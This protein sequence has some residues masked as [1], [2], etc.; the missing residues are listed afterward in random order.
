MQPCP[1]PP[2][3]TNPDT[4][5]QHH[6]T[7]Q[8]IDNARIDAFK[9]WLALY[10]LDQ[11]YGNLLA[12]VDSISQ[13]FPVVFSGLAAGLHILIG[14]TEFLEDLIYQQE[15]WDD[16]QWTSDNVAQF[17]KAVLGLET[18]MLAIATAFTIVSVAADAANPVLAL[19]LSF[20]FNTWGATIMAVT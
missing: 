14:W 6:P 16:S 17:T 8:Q 1:S 20:S 12:S 13:G 9:A 4:N 2:K 3:G 10:E 7:E 15:G 11:F 18:A 19:F 5:G